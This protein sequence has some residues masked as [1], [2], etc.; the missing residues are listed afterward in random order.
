AESRRLL[1]ELAAAWRGR[2]AG[3]AFLGGF[4]W[5]IASR[6]ARSA[7]MV[8]IT[9]G[10]INRN[11]FRLV[12]G[13]GLSFRK[14]L[15]NRHRSTGLPEYRVV[16]DAL[17]LPARSLADHRAFGDLGDDKFHHFSFGQPHRK[18]Q[19]RVEAV[20]YARIDQLPEIVAFIL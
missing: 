20:A 12:I 11:G 14:G 5:P 9:T 7:S 16:Q 8:R 15:V 2:A 1:R 4:V 3:V 19:L 17:L 10:A 6:G 18:A 13:I